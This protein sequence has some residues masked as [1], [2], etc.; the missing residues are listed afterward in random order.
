MTEVIFSLVLN[1]FKSSHIINGFKAIFCIVWHFLL[2]QCHLNVK[3]DR[4]KTIGFM[5]QVH[6]L[7]VKSGLTGCSSHTFGSGPT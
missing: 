5:M 7:K 3:A 6:I 1:A 4:C 2:S